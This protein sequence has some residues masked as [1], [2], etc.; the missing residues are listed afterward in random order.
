[1]ACPL[2]GGPRGEGE[3]GSVNTLMVSAMLQQA[4][5]RPSQPLITIMIYV[6][7]FGLIFWWLILRP[8]KKMQQKHQELVAGLKRGDEVMTEGGLVGS[9]VHLTEDRVTI[10]TGE[11]RVVV[12][13]GKVARIM[14]APVESSK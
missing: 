9:I 6:V 4:Q 12:A 14:S 3:G 2:P 8:Q 7:G 11:S 13:R 5:P 1:M 10:K